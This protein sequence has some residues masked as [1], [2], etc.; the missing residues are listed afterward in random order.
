MFE[1]QF[2]TISAAP[3]GRWKEILQPE[4]V[5]AL[6]LVAGPVM[7]RVGYALSGQISAM[8]KPIRSRMILRLLALTLEAKSPQERAIVD[9]AIAILQDP[10]RID[11][12]EVPPVKGEKPRGRF[13][14]A[15]GSIVR[16]S[17][18]FVKEIFRK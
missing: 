18:L 1:N 16:L 7:R 13:F 17:I 3:V 14:A 4:E 11:T 12:I 2:S 6:E 8:P 15:M 5:I 10:A 9:T